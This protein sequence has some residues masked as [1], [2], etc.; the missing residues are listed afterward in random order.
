MTYHDLYILIAI[1]GSFLVLGI[2]GILWGRKEERSWYRSIPNHVDIREFMEHSPLRPEPN[3]L[4]I[5]G[6]ICIALAIVIFLVSGSFY[7]W[8][9]VPVP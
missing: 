2:I 1:G 3:A 6:R 7:L 5:G 4:K 9:M 8:G